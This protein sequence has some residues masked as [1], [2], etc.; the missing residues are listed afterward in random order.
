MS[1]PPKPLPAA[2]PA[3]SRRLEQH[4]STLLRFVSIKGRGL[5]RHESAEDLVQGI[6]LRAMNTGASM[7]EAAPNELLAWLQVVARRH[8]A[9][10]YDYWT[11]L[12]RHAS[13]VIR[14]SVSGGDASG[15]PR[16]V[17]PAGQRTG[18]ATFAERREQVEIM[19][20]VLDGLSPRDR[21]ILRA[22]G[23]G[24]GNDELAARLGV[25]YEAA[26]VAKRRAMDRLR[27]A[28]AAAGSGS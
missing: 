24:G 22:V 16:G 21:E 5:L 25:S 15:R 14:I 8:I 23:A 6:H 1:G 2:D 11:A 26:E 18:P 7:K 27:R 20:R 17:D 12:R 3:L 13:R 9:D 4:R 10:R 28:F 19:T